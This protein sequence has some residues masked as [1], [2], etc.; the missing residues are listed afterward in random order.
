[1]ET[2]CEL[3]FCPR[4]SDVSAY[5]FGWRSIDPCSFSVN[6]FLCLFVLFAVALSLSSGSPLKRNTDP[7]KSKHV[8]GEC[9]KPY[10]RESVKLLVSGW[11]IIHVLEV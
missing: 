8:G 5:S 4:K 9:V 2:F 6:Q 3:I 11:R 7:E 1:M 10:W